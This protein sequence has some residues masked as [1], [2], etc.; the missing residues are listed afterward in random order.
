[1][2][3]ASEVYNSNLFRTRN[4]DDFF[5]GQMIRCT[6][7]TTHKPGGAWPIL[8]YLLYFIV[9][10]IRARHR[11][12]NKYTHTHTH[13]VFAQKPY[14]MDLFIC[15]GAVLLPSLPLFIVRRLVCPTLYITEL[16]TLI[17]NV[18]FSGDGWVS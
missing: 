18:L 4:S 14:E 15:R 11:Y 1:M 3:V 13:A 8:C 16:T 6:S 17:E 9:L 7:C 5:R 2:L 10:N 12:Y